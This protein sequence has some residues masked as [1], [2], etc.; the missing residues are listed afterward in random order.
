MQD[1]NKLDEIAEIFGLDPEELEIDF[2]QLDVEWGKQN[3]IIDKYLKASAY[4]EKMVRK[5]E[6]K[7][8]FIRSTLVL[9]VTSNPEGCLGKGQKATGP[10]IEAFYRTDKEY[11]EAKTEWIEAQYVCDLVNGQKS[12][13]YNRKTILEEATKLSLAGWFSA[14][15]VPRPLQEL[16]QKIEE[17][18][19]SNV[20][21]KIRE[22]LSEKATARAEAKEDENQ[23]SARRRRRR[24][25][26]S[27]E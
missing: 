21:A 7:I 11:L 9:K 5:A 20:D 12:K 27:D 26:N 18:K 14:P 3:S 8:K 13:A 23:E 24:T 6:E 1:E 25:E 17:Q 22:K 4:C 19:L 16:V 2:S 15:I 10:Q